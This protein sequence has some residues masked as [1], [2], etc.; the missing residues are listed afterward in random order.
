MYRIIWVGRIILCH[1]SNL[2]YYR[3]QNFISLFLYLLLNTTGFYIMVHIKKTIPIQ[4]FVPTYT[5]VFKE[6]LLTFNFVMFKD[7]YL[8][9]VDLSYLLKLILLQIPIPNPTNFI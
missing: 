9:I 3:K 2:L 1:S 7:I 8:L 6:Y 4:I 5:Y